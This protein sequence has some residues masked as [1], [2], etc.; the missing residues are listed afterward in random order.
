MTKFILRGM[1]I[2]AVALAS[3]TGAVE[4]RISDVSHIHGVGFDGSVAGAVL[5]ATHYGLYRALPDG[6]AMAVST[7]TSDYMGFSPDPSDSSRLLASG[8]PGQGG[9]IGVILSTDGGVNWTRIADGVNGPVDFHAMTISR[10]DPKVIY[11][12]YD[13]IQVSR[14]GGVSWTLAGPVPGQVID[15]AASA[16]SPDRLYAGTVDGLL[17]SKDASAS[18]APAGPA[19]VPA[20]MVEATDD[21]SLYAFFAGAGLFHLS[22]NGKWEALASGFGERY[23]LHLSAD[24]SDT[25]HLVAVND[26]SAVLESHDGGETWAE[27]GK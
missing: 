18:W 22:P 3:P 11:G 4:L 15:L 13:G 1:A 12:L 23:L 2:A 25:S 27:F 19:G 5:L 20:T 21:G 26:Q 14:D 8:H 10:A 24:P 7:D 17:E 16:S 6:A 9:N